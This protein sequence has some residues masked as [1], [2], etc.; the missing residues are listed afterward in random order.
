MNTPSAIRPSYLHATNKQ[1]AREIKKEIFRD[2]LS[3]LPAGLS[4]ECFSLCGEA[5]LEFELFQFQ[6]LKRNHRQGGISAYEQ[7]FDKFQ[8]NLDAHRRKLKSQISKGK[9]V[10]DVIMHWKGGNYFRLA[11]RTFES[12][13]EIGEKETTENIVD[14]DTCS[15][16]MAK[17]AAETVRILKKSGLA[18]FTFVCADRGRNSHSTGSKDYPRGMSADDIKNPDAIRAYIERVTGATCIRQHEYKNFGSPAKMV[19]L[20]FQSGN[21]PEVTCIES[22]K[23]YAPADS[24]ESELKEFVFELFDKGFNAP[25]IAT[26]LNLHMPTIRAWQAW[27]HPNLKRKARN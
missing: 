14:F 22:K 2:Y 8:K 10:G 20:V 27:R 17:T 3:T 15:Q 25:E 12:C 21:A 5:S 11:N 19:L 6:E 23:G 9:T 16:F 7:N 4:V 18:F 24:V 26:A 1:D 13:V